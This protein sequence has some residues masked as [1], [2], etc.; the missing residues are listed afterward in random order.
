MPTYIYRCNDCE[1]TFEEFH[2]MSETVE[3]CE[4]CG[5][6]VKRVLSN[7]FNVRKGKN[8]RGKKPGNV[9]KQYI[10]DVKEEIKQEKERIITQEYEAK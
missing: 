7:T 5:N 8:F 9:V 2:L 6:P 10:K 3:K 1:L 4:K